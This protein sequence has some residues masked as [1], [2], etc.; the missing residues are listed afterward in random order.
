MPKLGWPLQFSTTPV[1]PPRLPDHDSEGPTGPETGA[2]AVYGLSCLTSCKE[3]SQGFRGLGQ[4]VKGSYREQLWE[5]EGLPY[6]KQEGQGGEPGAQGGGGAGCR[7][8]RACP[9]PIQPGQPGCQVR[10]AWPGA[11]QASLSRLLHPWPVIPG[12]PGLA[13]PP[14]ALCC[15]YSRLVFIPCEDD[16]LFLLSVSVF[17]CEE[18]LACCACARGELVPRD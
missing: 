8:P 9:T 12:G 16:I 1:P 2:R 11:L 4:E 5:P 13:W 3:I 6:L 18:L 7:A 17:M 14:R 15:T 10:V